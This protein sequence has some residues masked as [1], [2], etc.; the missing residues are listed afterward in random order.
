MSLLSAA[1][2]AISNLLKSSI[3]TLNKCYISQ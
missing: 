1:K 2:E 3:L